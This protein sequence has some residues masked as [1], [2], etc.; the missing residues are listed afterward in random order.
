MKADVKMNLLADFDEIDVSQS[1][2]ITNMH[3]VKFLIKIL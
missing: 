2:E 3:N 1:P